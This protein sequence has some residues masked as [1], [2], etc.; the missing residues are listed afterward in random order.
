MTKSRGDHN[1]GI[2][3]EEAVDLPMFRSFPHPSVIAIN[4]EVVETIDIFKVEFDVFLRPAKESK[5]SVDCKTKEKL[6]EWNV[7]HVCDFIKL[8][9]RRV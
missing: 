3:F 9:L 2:V 1:W 7:H 5:L 8:G 4:D 6:R